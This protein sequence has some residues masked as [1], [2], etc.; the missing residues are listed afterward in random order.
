M[1]SLLGRLALSTAVLAAVLPGCARSG[2]PPNAGP[3]APA[4][5]AGVHET[6][7]NGVRHWYRIA[8]NAPADSRPVVFLHGGP[9]Q[10]SIHFAELVGPKLEPSLRMVYFDQRGS[11]RSERPASGEY[12]I[13]LLVEDL[14]QLRQALGVPR[15]SLIGQSF[16]GTLA[17]EYAARY[18]AHVDRLVFVAGLWDVPLQCRLR[19]N[20]LAQRRP[21]A[22]G[23]VRADTLLPDGTVRDGCGL[24]TRAFSSG[25]ER[26]AYNTEAM[27]PDTAVNTRMRAV[28]AAHGYRNTGELGGGLFRNGLLTYRFTSP[29]RLTMP[30][31]VIAG[32]HDGAARPEGLR[33]LA[34]RLPNARFVEYEGSGHFVYLDEPDRFAR[35]VIGFLSARR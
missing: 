33:E 30:V 8:G 4:S 27:F 21:E 11:G 29:D 14:E 17:L 28:E 3:P 1:G 31:L 10:G 22:Y 24:E 35:E 26:E 19:L 13:P 20:T 34:A 25:A 5:A 7:L 2:G 32:R 12:S 16:G 18:P 15:I 23:R 6:T 9:G